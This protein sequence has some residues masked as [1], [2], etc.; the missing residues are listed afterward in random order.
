M[1]L[2]VHEGLFTRCRLL[3]QALTSV[4]RQVDPEHP[5]AAR[6]LTVI[7]YSMETLTSHWRQ[8]PKP[9]A[10]E[11]AGT[12]D[13]AAGGEAAPAAP[14]AAAAAGA[15]G[16]SGAA[17]GGSSAGH[18]EGPGNLVTP[19]PPGAR[20]DATPVPPGTQV[21]FSRCPALL[22]WKEPSTSLHP[23][24]IQQLRTKCKSEARD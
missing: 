13:A 2:V 24:I 17:P 18:A 7:L 22:T 1:W 23:M 21:S 9:K 15:A 6:T 20:P 14:G 16:S 5:R 10:G 8:K 3:L 11:A 12:A 4:M 19:A